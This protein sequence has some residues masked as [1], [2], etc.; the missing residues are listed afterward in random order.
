MSR[1]R[2]DLKTGGWEHAFGPDSES[3]VDV[4]FKTASAT[5][6]RR[7]PGL[8]SRMMVTIA[9]RKRVKMSRMRGWYQTEQAQEFRMLAEFAYHRYKAEQQC[10]EQR[11]GCHEQDSAPA[12]PRIDHDLFSSLFSVTN[13]PEDFRNQ[14][15]A[16]HR[17]A[18][19]VHSA[20]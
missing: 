16:R 11:Q 8:P 2:C 5:T 4:A 10:S 13:G 17:K 12:Q 20:S 18:L 1:R 9:Y 19:R 15:P 14:R 6:Q 3:G 7:P